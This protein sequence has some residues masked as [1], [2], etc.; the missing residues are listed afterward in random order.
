MDNEAFD[1]TDRAEQIALVDQVFQLE[2]HIG[3][4]VFGHKFIDAHFVGVQKHIYEREFARVQNASAKVEGAE[5][6]MAEM[7]EKF[8]AEGSEIYQKVS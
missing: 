3:Y 6:G 8:K 7:S 4:I 1:G 2:H 5:A